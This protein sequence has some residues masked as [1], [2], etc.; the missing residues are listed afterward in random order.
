MPTS[1][2]EHEQLSKTLLNH[3][4]ISI[5]DPDGIIVYA[6][7]IFLDL[8]GYTLNEL[9]G[10]KHSIL[11]SGKQSRDFYKLLWYNITNKKTWHGELFNKK[12]DNTYYS[13]DATITPLLNSKNEI[14]YFLSVHHDITHNKLLIDQL[15]EQSIQQIALYLLSQKS[16][17]ISD[18]E[19]YIKNTLR[20]CSELFEI[21]HGYSISLKKE[22]N[23]A[24][25]N[26]TNGIKIAKNNEHYIQLSDNDILT[27]TL[28][29][30]EPMLIEDLDS[31]NRFEIPSPLSEQC[32]KS[33]VCFSI[34]IKNETPTILCLFDDK[35]RHFKNSDTSFFQTVQT[36]ITETNARLELQDKLKKE[37]ELTET[38]LDSTEELA[39]ILDKR[40]RIVFVNKKLCN[41]LGLEKASLINTNFVNSFVPINEHKKLYSHY[42][43]I[44]KNTETSKNKKTFF[45]HTNNITTEQGNTRLIKWNNTLLFNDN[46]S[47]SYLC[48]GNDITEITKTR[49]KQ[50]KLKKQLIQAQKMESLGL[51]AGGIS[52]DFNN[53]LASILGFSELA[54]EKYASNKDEKLNFYLSEINEACIRG[55]GIISQ[56][57]SL[58]KHKDKKPHAVILENMIDNILKMLQPVIPPE[59]NIKKNVKKNIPAVNATPANINQIVMN[60]IINAKE[61]I[62]DNGIINIGIEKFKNSERK[63]S[64]CKNKI[65]GDYINLSIKDTGHG[66]DD[67]IIKNIFTPHISTKSNNSKQ[68]RGIGLS[69]VQNIVHESNG[70]IIVDTS[71]DGTTFNVLFEIATGDT[72]PVTKPVVRPIK[73]PINTKKHIM[74]VDDE[75]SIAAYLGE[76]F[77]ELGY[78]V[79]VFID[80]TKALN[81]FSN[82]P[83][84]YDLILSDQTMPIITG[85]ELAKKTLEIKPDLPFVIHTGHSDLIDKDETNKIGIKGFLKKPVETHE[86]L[87]CITELL[88]NKENESIK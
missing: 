40:Y 3:L 47:H 1:P 50:K 79:S 62:T 55:K 81:A 44:V 48:T 25:I 26:I 73:P 39:I 2:L 10:K 4:A 61:A 74:I 29:N 9:I 15:R 38:Y 45:S 19:S 82:A 7:N 41:T 77:S 20:I 16:T 36:L 11:G 76:L 49:K 46:H 75:N 30:K 60:L 63:C 35:K 88:E 18:I 33:A 37:K 21:K 8:C 59:I 23:K 54:I 67:E 34:D 51:L 42:N 32:Y 6:N 53:I 56:L 12:K 87:K 68:E 65:S 64:S 80:P 43:Y 84:S 83:E 66:I 14:E 28:N 52:H 22:K 27:Y 70:H 86:L 72:E 17:T 5:T 24:T 57:V 85:I 71:K 58:N 13:V 69:T 31:E 78:K